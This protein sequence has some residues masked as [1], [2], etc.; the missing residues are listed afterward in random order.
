VT[1][2]VGEHAPHA[3]HPAA[4]A[5]PPRCTDYLLLES[6]LKDIATAGWETPSPI[7]AQCLAPALAGR[8]IIGLAQTGTGKT[9]AFALPIIQKL[10]GRLE[11]G[12]LVLAPTRELA[13]QIVAMF[14]ELGRS[15]GTRV[16]SIYGGVP[17]D[18]DYK[19][20]QSWPNVLVATPGRLI[21]HIG[22]GTV[23]LKEIEI[24]AVDEAD[25]MHDMG[26][27]PQIRRILAALPEKRQTLMFTATMPPDV[28]KIVRKTMINPVRI[29]VGRQVPVDRPG[30]AR[31]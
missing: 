4:H 2:P 6:I 10:A 20:L 30:S 29:Q 25:R 28:E 1:Q 27:M 11:L 18:N 17:M 26:F 21:D 3:A 14:R 24:F 16:V 13:H 5:K 19:A 23:S 22:L 8:D 12:G 15:S 31:G 9:G 7:Q